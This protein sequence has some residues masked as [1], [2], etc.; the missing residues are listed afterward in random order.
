VTLER[1]SEVEKFDQYAG[2]YSEAH[3][4]SVRLSGEGPAFFAA[5]KL[6]CLQRLGVSKA[7]RILDF[8][9]GIG[10]LT[11]LLVK[12]YDSV[13]A[14]DPSSRSLEVASRELPQATFYADA[15]AIPEG[16]FAAVILSGVLHHVAPRERP[17]LLA[18]ASRK[19]APGGR[20]CVFE[21]N[22]YNPLTQKAVRDCPFDDDAI[23]L[24]PREL[25]SLLSQAGFSPVRQQYVLFFPRPLAGLR[26]FEQ[27]LS[28]LPLGAQTLTVGL[29][30]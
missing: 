23:L 26:R 3:A 24:R 19:L 13:S 15:A 20:L 11:R 30:A 4:Q 12:E 6:G 21:H 17:A 5:H 10:T 16:S 27:L 14:Y 22:P 18:V 29:K 28:W 1:A 9:C 8:G 2:S 25:R 7:D